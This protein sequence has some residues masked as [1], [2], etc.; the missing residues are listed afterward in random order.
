[1]TLI[2]H[3]KHIAK[4]KTDAER[5]FIYSMPE[6]NTGCWIWTA[7]TVKGGYGRAW[8]YENHKKILAHRLSYQTFIG[9]IPNG[10]HVDHVCRNTLC[11]NPLH[12][13]AVTRLVNNRRSHIHRVK[14]T[15]CKHGHEFTEKN[16]MI[17]SSGTRACRLC[18]TLRQRIKYAKIKAK[19]K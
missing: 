1:M 7:D 19:R 17:S 10:L 4:G 3:H 6:P 5:L 14:K 2:K 9:P 13:E 12:L 15:H 11:I 16:T 18:S 8:D